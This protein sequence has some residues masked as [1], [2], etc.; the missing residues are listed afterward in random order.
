MVPLSIDQ[1]ADG[2]KKQTATANLAFKACP[3]P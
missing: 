1:A 3:G 2:S